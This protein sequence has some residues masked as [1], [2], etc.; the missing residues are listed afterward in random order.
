MLDSNKIS[1]KRIIACFAI[2]LLFTIVLIFTNTSNAYAQETVLASGT[3]GNISWRAVY[4]DEA[5]YDAERAKTDPSF[6]TMRILYLSG[7]GDMED[8]NSSGVMC[9]GTKYAPWLINKGYLDGYEIPSLDSYNK[10]V[11]GDGIKSIGN[12]A[13]TYS[14]SFIWQFP[15]KEIIIPNS[16]TRIGTAAF[17]NSPSER[18]VVPDSVKTIG[19]VAFN[20]QSTIVCNYGSAAYDYCIQNE[21][22]MEV[23]GLNVGFTVNGST[24]ATIT[25]G[26][27]VSYSLTSNIPDI[28]P[29][30]KSEDPDLLSVDTENYTITA[31]GSGYTGTVKAYFHGMNWEIKITVPESIDTAEIMIPSQVYTGSA[32]TP[33]PDVWFEGIILKNGTDYTIS[34]ENNVNAGTA[35]AVFTGVGSYAGTK[36]VTFSI[37][38]A[39]QPMKVSAKK[40]AKIKYS[41][42]KKKA[43]TLKASKVMKITKYKG[44]LTYKKTKGNKRIT[45]NQ[46]TGKI[47]IA[48]KLKKGTYSVKIKVTASGNSNYKKGSKTVTVNIKVK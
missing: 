44:T 15:P 27:T 29:T 28:V 35:T 48:K 7:N 21:Q 4:D 14:T 24:S 43:Q 37:N 18:I 47:K 17:Y 41:T 36:S 9:P 2:L 30:I 23:T 34:Y 8:Y 1:C 19:G 32:V 5:V 11:I 25:K 10:I 13:F 16:V 42:L 20:P 12:C 33:Q 46:K 22:L 38:K 39:S 40:T 45:V 3:D 31:I 26:Q 6:G